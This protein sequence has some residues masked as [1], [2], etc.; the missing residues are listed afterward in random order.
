MKTIQY[1]LVCA[2]VVALFISGCA[3]P[4]AEAPAANAAA[5]S[6]QS[7]TELPTATTAAATEVPATATLAPTPLPTLDMAQVTPVVQAQAGAAYLIQ[8]VVSQQVLTVSGANVE[9]QPYS[10]APEQLWT[11]VAQSDGSFSLQTADGQHCLDAAGGA[12][13]GEGTLLQV[14]P[15]DGS[16]A[17]LWSTMACELSSAWACFT[18]GSVWL[19]SASGRFLDLPDDSTT[20]GE[21]IITLAFSHGGKNQ[22]WYLLAAK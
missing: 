4:S 20:A 11:M 15:C 7:A 10:G 6:D 19:Q 12:A 2:L 17:Q 1:T 14:A 16:A 13:S 9:Q 18:P 21:K 8:S 5:P 3:A 22:Q